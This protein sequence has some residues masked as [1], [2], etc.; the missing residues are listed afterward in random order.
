M[1][2][3]KQ[4]RVKLKVKQCLIAERLGIQRTNYNSIEN[5]KLIPNNIESIER[6]AL[7]LLKP[8]LLKK[9]DEITKELIELQKIREKL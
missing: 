5:G 8:V 6:D 9:I 4:L 1:E 2:K 3:V 7:F